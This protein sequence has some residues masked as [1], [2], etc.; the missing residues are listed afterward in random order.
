MPKSKP[1]DEKTKA[2]A[3][4]Q[5]APS[6]KRDFDP[7]D[8]F[9]SMANAG[10]SLPLLFTPHMVGLGNELVR[11]VT[12][13]S[14][15]QPRKDDHRFIDA[16]WQ[17][18]PIYRASMQTYLAWC[19]S[20]NDLVSDSTLDEH[21]K[22]KARAAI[23]YLSKSLSPSHSTSNKRA[24][25]QAFET[26]GASLMHGLRMMTEDVLKHSGIPGKVINDTYRVGENI[27]TTKGSVVYRSELLE[28]IQ[29]KPLKRKTF[30][31]PL[32]MVPS[33][34]N[35]YYLCDLTPDNS[36]ASYL[37]RQGQQ[38][39]IVS[40]RNPK[41]EQKHWGLDAYIDAL[42]ECSKVTSKIADSPKI[43]LFGFSAGGIFAALAAN[44]MGP[45][46]SCPKVNSATFAVTNFD[47]HAESQVGVLINDGIIEASKTVANL[48]GA[49]NG[50]EM[51]R[52]FA[53]MRPNGLLW[54]AWVSNYFLNEELPSV[55]IMHWNNDITR[56]PSGLHCD[57][58]ELYRNNPLLEKDQL[59]VCGSKIDLGK[60]KCDS[61]LLAGATDHITPWE[62]CYQSSMVLG[63][64]K[65]F[66]LVNRGHSRSIISPPGIEGARYYT[67]QENTDSPE[68]W[69]SEA[70]QRNGSWWPHWAKW[71]NS[72]SGEL[73]A[74]PK[75]LGSD[76]YPPLMDA[77]GSYLLE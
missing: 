57:F 43:N 6:G 8:T 46:R 31:I 77:P 14:Q 45:K 42:V 40:W 73:T 15:I 70:S 54:N 59:T 63:G 28:L 65:E 76:Q 71:L 50:Q 66:V 47:T 17:M 51:A 30:G 3:K 26:R 20:L 23:K 5:P 72:R 74:A 9:A 67:H 44:I 7:W 32:L 56:I 10:I 19:G 22:K 68:D 36:L 29:Y 2:A 13:Q 33:P 21:S 64:N 35:R 58:L 48:R 1:E 75:A 60:V 61:Y 16:N 37:L 18:N 38:V 4:E 55:D 52:M 39:Y 27:A 24:M 49:M 69:L 34:I 25:H 53:W 12:G 62:G 41:R 11:I